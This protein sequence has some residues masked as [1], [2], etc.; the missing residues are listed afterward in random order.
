MERV[1]GSLDVYAIIVLELVLLSGALQVA[2][3]NYNRG[4]DLKKS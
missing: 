3:I 4:C 1:I 2:G